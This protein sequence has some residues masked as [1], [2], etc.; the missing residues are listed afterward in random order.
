MT[1]HDLK[2]NNTL[3]TI[4]DLEN[5]LKQKGDVYNSLKSATEAGL[6]VLFQR[7]NVN[8]KSVVVTEMK[9]GSLVVDYVV[10]FDVNNRNISLQKLNPVKKKTDIYLKDSIFSANTSPELSQVSGKFL[11]YATG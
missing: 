6:Y 7:D 10:E 9:S 8:V 1:L 2:I 4:R 5:I 3:T 11:F